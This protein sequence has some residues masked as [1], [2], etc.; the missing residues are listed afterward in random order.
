MLLPSKVLLLFSL[1][2]IMAQKV[3]V[4]AKIKVRSTHF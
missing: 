1:R 3:V 4:M 2:V